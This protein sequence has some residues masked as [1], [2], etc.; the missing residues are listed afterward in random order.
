MTAFTHLR[1]MC[2]NLD[3]SKVVFPSTEEHRINL[4]HYCPDP[5]GEEIV[6]IG[7]R[8]EQNFYKVMCAFVKDMINGGMRSPIDVTGVRW[9][10]QELSVRWKDLTTDGNVRVGDEKYIAGNYLMEFNKV[11]RN[12]SSTVQSY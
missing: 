9:G 1:E 3:C 5:A 10:E 6:S 12:S 7:R 4:R 11:C 8:Y 2:S